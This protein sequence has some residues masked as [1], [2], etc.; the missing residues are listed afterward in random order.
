AGAFAAKKMVEVDDG[1]PSVTYENAVSTNIW[2]W[3]IGFYNIG[4]ERMIGTAISIRPRAFYFGLMGADVDFKIFGFG[5]DLFYHP[6]NNGIAGWFVGP[7]YDVWMATGGSVT[8]AMHFL[9][10]MGGY[11]YVFDGGF[12]LGIS[13]GVQM[14][15]MNSINDSNIG[16]YSGTMPAFDAEMGWSF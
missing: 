12:T 9:G 6:M 3:L 5:A 16:T 11:K 2:P 15:I 4:Y 1:A 7:R 10:V 14:N 8:G 13:L